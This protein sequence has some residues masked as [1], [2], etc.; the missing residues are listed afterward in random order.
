MN[1]EE[2]VLFDLRMKVRLLERQISDWKA[3]ELD[4]KGTEARLLETNKELRA[5]GAK[6]RQDLGAALIQERGKRRRKLS[7]RMLRLRIENDRLRQYQARMWHWHDEA[8]AEK[9]HSMMVE[10]QNAELA[11]ELAETKPQRK[12]G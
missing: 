1:A 3:E 8:Q 9:M 12:E 4:W 11:R 5:W 10:E 2:K 7:L 6:V